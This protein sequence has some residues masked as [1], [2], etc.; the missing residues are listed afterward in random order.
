MCLVNLQNYQNQKLKRIFYIF[1]KAHSFG[2]NILWFTLNHPTATNF[3][4]LSVEMSDEIFA[5]DRSGKEY[6]PIAM[7]CSVPRSTVASVIVN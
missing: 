6:K 7:S 1:K 4:E 2:Y 3:Q 5:K